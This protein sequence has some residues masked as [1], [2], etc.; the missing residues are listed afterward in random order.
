MGY[1]RNEAI[2]ATL[3]REEDFKTCRDFFARLP[4]WER[5]LCVEVPARINGYVTFFIAPDGSKEG[6]ADSDRGDALRDEFKAV[7]ADMHGWRVHVTVSDENDGP[8]VVE[9]PEAIE[10]GDES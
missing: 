3:W 6:W 5:S 10:K 7:I 2:I 9:I 4:E 8:S 1:M